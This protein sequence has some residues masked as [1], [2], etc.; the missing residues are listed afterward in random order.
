MITSPP[1]VNLVVIRSEDIDR[2]VTFYE[3]IGL[4]FQKHSHGSGPEHYASEKAGFV[5]EI[6]PL[7]PKQ[8]S[9]VWTRLGFSVGDVDALVARLAK[10]GAKIVS[11]PTDSEW[12][13]RAVVKD[14]DGHAVELVEPNKREQAAAPNP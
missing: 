13:R 1:F 12:G 6:Y 9:T 7:S 11:S 10:D 2:A 5:F 14:L 4:T 8:Q 3:A